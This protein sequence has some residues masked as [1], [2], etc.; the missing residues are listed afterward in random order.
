MRKLKCRGFQGLTPV[1]SCPCAQPGGCRMTE[2]PQRWRTVHRLRQPCGSDASVF[3]VTH[4][5]LEPI[6]RS[7]RTGVSPRN[8]ASPS[9]LP[10]IASNK[11]SLEQGLSDCLEAICWLLELMCAVTYGSQVQHNLGS[12]LPLH[13]LKRWDCYWLV[14]GRK[15]QSASLS[16]QMQVFL[17]WL[18]CGGSP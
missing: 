3:T 9:V 2:C 16:K 14:L 17:K 4:L 7:Q 18:V 10:Y 11:W 6:N 5:Y 8:W 1:L 12:S 15:A 13:E